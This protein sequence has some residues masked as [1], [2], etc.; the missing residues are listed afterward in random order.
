MSAEQHAPAN[1]TEYIQHH[2]LSL[3]ASHDLPVDDPGNFHLD[4]F[5]ISLILGFI[6]IAA[7]GLVARRASVDKPSKF[8]LFV[9]LIVELVDTNVKEIFHGKSKLVAPLG[10]TVFVWVFL[11]NA[12][13]FL[14]VDLLPRIV[15][16]FGIHQLK[17]VPTADINQ[18]LAMSLSVVLLSIGLGIQAKGFVGF[19]TEFFTTPF[20]AD[21]VVM[22]I[23]LLPVNA[24]MQCVEYGSRILSLA[25]RLVGNMFAG[26]LVFMLIALLGMTWTGFNPGSLLAMFGQ[27]VAGSVWAIFHILIVLLQAYIFMMLTIVYCG[28]AVEDH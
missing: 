21:G 5:W 26:E 16:M 25:L 10:L 17:V 14:P 8:Q 11:M 1:A 27:V 15:A 9:E 12:M 18:G 7:F 6:F 23:I 22:K 19:F 24:F 2:L 13:D 4:T 3:R 28:L 20:H